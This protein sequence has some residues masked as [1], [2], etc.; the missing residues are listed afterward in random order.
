M[1]IY[2]FGWHKNNET[3]LAVYGTMIVKYLPKLR[4]RVIC[5][6]CCRNINA[7][8]ECSLTQKRTKDVTLNVQKKKMP[9]D[10]R[11]TLNLFLVSI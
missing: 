8:C 4:P 1:F 2:G 3:P 7:V 5:L 11:T 10:H 9:V 6:A